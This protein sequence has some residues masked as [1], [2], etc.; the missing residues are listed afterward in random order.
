[1]KLDTESMIGDG[2]SVSEIECNNNFVLLIAANID[3]TNLN[4]IHISANSTIVHLFFVSSKVNT[5]VFLE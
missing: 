3:D 4:K 1:M 2:T 5:Y